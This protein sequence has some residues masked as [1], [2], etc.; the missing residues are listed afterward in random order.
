MQHPISEQLDLPPA[1]QIGF[2]FRD[3][4]SAIERYRPV[5]GDFEIQDFGEFEY[6]YRGQPEKAQV[7]CAFAYT[8]DL[9]IE[10]IGWVSGGTPHKEFLDAGKEGVHHLRFPVDKLEDAV[11]DAKKIGY[12]PIWQTRFGEGL[13]VA[14][15]E[16]EGEE[17]LLEFFEN[18]Q[19]VKG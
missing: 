19:N 5:F 9:Q 2:V 14:Y 13:A 10:F 16:K 3:L 18:H 6:E 8:G 12:E 15:M 4:E 11:E 7:T 1:D 17:L